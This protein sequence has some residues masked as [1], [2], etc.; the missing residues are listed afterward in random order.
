MGSG[1]V[2]QRESR[3]SFPIDRYL[4]VCSGLVHTNMFLNAS[5][6]LSFGLQMVFLLKDI[7]ENTSAV[8]CYELSHV[9]RKANSTFSGVDEELLGNASVDGKRSESGLMQM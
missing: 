8:S 9:R 7:S 5:F 2:I 4:I 1:N 3:S 6:S